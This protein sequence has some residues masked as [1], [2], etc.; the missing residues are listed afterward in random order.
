MTSLVESVQVTSVFIPATAEIMP[1]TD[2]IVS[3]IDLSLPLHE[4]HMAGQ[5]SGEVFGDVLTVML[6]YNPFCWRL[7]WTKCMYIK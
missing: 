5:S 3:V 1:V 7:P 4:R 2:I 6:L